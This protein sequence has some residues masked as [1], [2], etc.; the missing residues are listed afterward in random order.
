MNA[1]PAPPVPIPPI[2]LTSYHYAAVM[3]WLK[4]QLRLYKG[5]A[6]KILWVVADRTFGHRK[7]EDVIALSQF[8]FDAGIGRD[9]VLATLADLLAVGIIRRRPVGNSYAYRLMI[10]E[11]LFSDRPDESIDSAVE[12]P[13]PVI[14]TESEA[15]SFFAQNPEV[16]P[17]NEGALAGSSSSQIDNVTECSNGWNRVVEIL[18]A[19]ADLNDT[20]PRATYALRN[21]P[22][23]AH[24]A[25]TLGMHWG[26][27]WSLWQACLRVGRNPVALFLH[28]LQHD[29]SLPTGK[30]LKR[31]DVTKRMFAEM[32]D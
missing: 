23:W 32:L 5:A 1:P 8:A 18:T 25:V 12:N 24:R 14:H 22:R 7:W 15:V 29:G 19:L 31:Q 16:Y 11:D 30:P 27:V 9:T 26:D 28:R 10:P 20:L 2:T 13:I 17:Q 21:L 4:G 3:H 6:T